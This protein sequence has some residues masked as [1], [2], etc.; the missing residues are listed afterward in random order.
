MNRPADLAPPRRATHRDVLD[1]PE[2][3]IA[4]ILD[5]ALRL[6]LRPA[7]RHQAAV[8]ALAGAL[9]GPFGKGRGGPGG[10]WFA[11]EPELHLDGDVLVPDLAGWRIGPGR[12][13][14]AGAAARTAPDWACEILSPR[15]RLYDRR[16][17]RARYAHH[18]VAFLWLLAPDA[19]TLETFALAG[20]G[21]WTLTGAFGPGDALQAAPFEALPIRFDD[22]S[23]ALPGDAPDAEAEA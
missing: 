11:V 16:E 13:A 10:W 19:R 9:D 4:E 14:P 12:P 3:M 22:L 17:K 23:P 2:D 20:D 5:G 6:Q 8:F 21:R 7:L 1:A 18:G 15:T